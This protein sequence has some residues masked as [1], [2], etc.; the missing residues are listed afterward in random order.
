[1]AREVCVEYKEILSKKD[2]YRLNVYAVERN[3]RSRVLESIDSLTQDKKD[4]VINLLQKMA[5]NGTE[6]KSPKVKWRLAKYSY[7]ELKPHGHRFFFFVKV[8]EN[9]ILFDYEEK[10]KGSLK[11]DIYKRLQTE[12]K[13]YEREFERFTSGNKENL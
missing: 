2:G 8:N 1:M 10:K 3:S 6:Y 5:E 9:L 7:G 4:E 11:S 12:M 13:Y